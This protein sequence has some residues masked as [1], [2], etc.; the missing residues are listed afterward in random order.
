MV[1]NNVYIGSAVK[2]VGEIFTGRGGEWNPLRFAFLGVSVIS[3]VLITR[4][5][6][7]FAT[8]T[9]PSTNGPQT[10]LV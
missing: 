4:T 6:I 2:D 8:K 10:K 3:S 1:I 7:K 9:A 5:F